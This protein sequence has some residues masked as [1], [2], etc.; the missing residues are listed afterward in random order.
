MHWRSWRRGVISTESVLW[1]AIGLHLGDI[2]FAEIQTSI[3]MHAV[4]FS[5]FLHYVEEG[6]FNPDHLAPHCC[7]QT[8]AILLAFVPDWCLEDIKRIGIGNSGNVI[9]S[10]RSKV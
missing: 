10:I 1:S 6:F 8:M 5:T 4:Q 3:K 2:R 9:E 7:S